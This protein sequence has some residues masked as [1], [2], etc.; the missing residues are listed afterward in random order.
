MLKNMIL[1][2]FEMYMLQDNRQIADKA[3]E[4]FNR[5]IHRYRIE[6]IMLVS[7]QKNACYVLNNSIQSVLKKEGLLYDEL[8]EV[9]PQSND[10][11]KFTLHSGDRVIN[12]ENFHDCPSSDK[13]SK[14]SVMNGSLGT[15]IGKTEHKNKKGKV[16]KTTYNIYFEGIGIGCY[17]KSD[18][19]KRI[20]L[21]YCITV[22]KSQGSQSKLLIYVHPE[23]C[24]SKLNCSEMVYTA[25]TR[26]RDKAIV[27]SIEN[28]LKKAIVTKELNSKQTLLKEFLDTY[29][30]DTFQ[31]V[32]HED[33]P[34]E[35]TYNKSII[36]VVA[37][38]RESKGK[39]SSKETLN[40]DSKTREKYDKNNAQKRAKR[41]NKNGLL[42]K[43]QSKLDKINLIKDLYC[44]GKSQKEIVE[45]TGFAKGTVSKYLRL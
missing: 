3:I 20:L 15:V 40:I 32:L 34:L 4:V 19:E 25:I 35:E 16:Y 27:I 17:S 13:D 42:A 43:E 29:C 24:Y 39:K 31:G 1:E 5:Y 36:E 22:H 14:I 30:D 12:V 37:E 44:Q 2:D 38:K 8:I 33:K 26:A 11:L 21:G 9:S 6:D 10:D 7:P 45:I 18:L 23:R 41:R 28:I